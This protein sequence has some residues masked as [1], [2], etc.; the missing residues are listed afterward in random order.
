MIMGQQ[1]I[2]TLYSVSFYSS[3]SINPLSFAQVG[4]YI[5]YVLKLLQDQIATEIYQPGVVDLDYSIIER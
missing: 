2:H 3:F 1:S 4:P 5:I